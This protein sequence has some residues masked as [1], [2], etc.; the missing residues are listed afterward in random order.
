MSARCLESERGRNGGE[1]LGIGEEVAEESD[2][3]L[4]RVW[5]WSKRRKGDHHRAYD[6]RLPKSHIMCAIKREINQLIVGD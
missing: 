1:R 5:G 2:G 4:K 3:Q 6:R